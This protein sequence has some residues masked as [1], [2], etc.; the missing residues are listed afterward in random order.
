[1]ERARKQVTLAQERAETSERHSLRE[2]DQDCAA[3]KKSQRMAENL[4]TE[5]A[6]ARYERAM[7]R[8]RRL[9]ARLN[10][11][12]GRRARRSIRGHRAGAARN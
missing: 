10:S 9:R 5:L 8:W 6:A 1:M 11:R 7:R 3:R 2:L 4:R 12:P